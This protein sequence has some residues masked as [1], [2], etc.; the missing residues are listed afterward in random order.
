MTIYARTPTP[1]A[2]AGR[3]AFAR[4]NRKPARGQVENRNIANFARIVGKYSPSQQ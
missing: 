3:G 1:A 2:A 4:Q